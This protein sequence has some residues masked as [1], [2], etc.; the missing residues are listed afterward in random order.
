[1]KLSDRYGLG[2]RTSLL[3]EAQKCGDALVCLMEE[4]PL[5]QRERIDYLIDRFESLR[6]SC[7]S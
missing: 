3:A 2:E 1:M 6:A 5:G 7:L 4:A